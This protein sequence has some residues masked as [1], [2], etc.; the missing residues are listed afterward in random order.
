MEYDSKR[1]LCYNL[2]KKLG[3]AEERFNYFGVT[4]IVKVRPFIA[5]NGRFCAFDVLLGEDGDTIAIVSLQHYTTNLPFIRNDKLVN[6]KRGVTDIMVSVS[7]LRELNMTF[8]DV[9]DG[10]LES[11]WVAANAAYFN[12]EDS[13]SAV[14]EAAVYIREVIK[15]E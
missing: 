2:A 7:S 9:I 8:K 3:L 12:T 1:S 11:A 10:G 6:E 5:P 4:E 13:D 14:Y 15:G